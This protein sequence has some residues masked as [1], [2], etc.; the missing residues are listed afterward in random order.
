MG[1]SV[2]WSNLALWGLIGTWALVVG[3][4]V[5]MWWQTRSARHLN[6]ANAILEMRDRFDSREMRRARA[7]FATWLLDPV[8]E[9]PTSR[10][11]DCSRCLGR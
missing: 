6:S 8:G 10:C 4:L 2:D 5:L 7:Q 3:T 11:P 9:T 1:I